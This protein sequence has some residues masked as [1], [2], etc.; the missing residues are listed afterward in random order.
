MLMRSKQ[1]TWRC[2]WGPQSQLHYPDC[3]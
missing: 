2:R 3:N 1:N